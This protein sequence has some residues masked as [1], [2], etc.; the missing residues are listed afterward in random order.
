MTVSLAAVFIPLV[1]MGGI[2]GR[3]LHE[4]AV[5]I[6]FA[7]VVSGIVSVTLTPMLCSR[8]LKPGKGAEHG[9]FY[10]MSEHAFDWIQARYETSL[11]W[12]VDHKPLVLAVFV[13]SLVATVVLFMVSK[14]DFLPSDDTARSS[15][16]PWAPTA[17]RSTRWPSCSAAPRRS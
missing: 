13:L 7:I 15:A 9:R 16:P 5:T 4:F 12:S 10:Q 1:F 3:L 11:H 8:F 14:T 17:S 2:V 6:V